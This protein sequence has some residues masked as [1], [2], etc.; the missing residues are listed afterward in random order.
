[1]VRTLLRVA[2]VL[3]ALSVGLALLPPAGAGAEARPAWIQRAALALPFSGTGYVTQGWGGAPT[4]SGN[5]R[6][7]LDFVTV[8]RWG[9]AYA[10]SGRDLTDY[11]TWGIPVLAPAEGVVVGLE[12]GVRDNPID[13]PNRDD[14]WGNY[15]LIEHG[16]GEFSLIAHFRQGSLT[17]RPGQ[18][19]QKGQRLGLAG[20]SGLSFKP[21]IHYQLQGS[22]DL[23]AMT[24]PAVFE[25]YYELTWFRRT[26]KTSQTPPEGAYVRSAR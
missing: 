10:R 17:V 23:D 20:N 4:H 24:L 16:S 11:Y 25:S 5:Q 8:N 7:S 13:K 12:N 2:V 9:W 3:A 15:V 14:P 21:H 22:A 6:Y 1:M 19:V 26:L 18:R